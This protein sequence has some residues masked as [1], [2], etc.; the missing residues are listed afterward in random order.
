MANSSLLETRL[1]EGFA[2]FPDDIAGGVWPLLLVRKSGLQ[3]V[4][5]QL[6]RFLDSIEE[7]EFG[8]HRNPSQAM[9]KHTA[10]SGAI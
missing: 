7:Q 2:Y 10:K 3:S 1:R 9:E 8:Q 6:I 4:I 5:S